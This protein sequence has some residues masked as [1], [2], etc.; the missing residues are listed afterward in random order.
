MLIH[1]IL[2]P[3]D[4]GRR[5]VRMGA[6]PASL[7]PGLTASLIEAG[8]EVE[9]A[10]VEVPAVGWHA[11]VA[12]AFALANGVAHKVDAA[13]ARGAFPI[14]LSGN[15]FATVGVAA[16]LGKR[17][18]V[19]WFDAHADFHTPET[20]TSGF[21]DGMAL[22]TL[23]GEGWEALRD[24]VS[25]FV[26]VP[27]RATWLVGARDL[28]PA[29]VEALERSRVHRVAAAAV[30]DDLGDSIR[31]AADEI[32]QFAV[33]LD[34]DVID[35]SEGRAN[36]YA[37]AGGVS[38]ADLAAAC[39][40]LGRTLAVGALTVSAYDPACDADR[41]IRAIADASVTAVVEALAARS[42]A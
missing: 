32:D 23:T 25:G 15:C 27:E 30:G 31:R 22:R 16:G 12:A 38:G 10:L 14:V 36:P 8:C 20:S 13:R 18:G 37:V 35:V 4:S 19:V 5:D 7:A 42:A 34:L 28:D 2:V 6:G 40:S 1:L 17:T 26:P 41:R 29:E 21:L 39:R 9:Q 3:Y 11:E 24:K 33:H